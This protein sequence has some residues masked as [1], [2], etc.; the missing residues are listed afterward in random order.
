[1]HAEPVALPRLNAD[2]RPGQRLSRDLH[3]EALSLQSSQ[4]L[5]VVESGDLAGFG[6]RQDC[7]SRDQ[8]AGTSPTSRLIR[9]RDGVEADP[10]ERS[11]VA[12][13]TAVATHLDLPG[14]R[15]CKLA[16]DRH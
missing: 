5:G 10:L 13:Q 1:M 14:P 15:R 7:R 3:I 9:A 11:F 16:E 8:R 12:V 2:H 6:V 4:Q